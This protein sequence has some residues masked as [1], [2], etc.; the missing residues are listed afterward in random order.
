MKTRLLCL[1]L[2]IL[3]LGGLWL[4]PVRTVDAQEHETTVAEEEEVSPRGPG[5]V[6]LMVGVAALV[7]VGF[8]YSSRQNTEQKN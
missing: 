6:I 8:T 4:V 3:L 5:A 2:G 7:V 1:L